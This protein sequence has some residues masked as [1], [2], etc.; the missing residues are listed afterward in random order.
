L[1]LLCVVVWSV[2]TNFVQVFQ[3]FISLNLN[4]FYNIISTLTLV[5]LHTGSIT[6]CFWM[7]EEAQPNASQQNTVSSVDASILFDEDRFLHLK[8]LRADECY[9]PLLLGERYF[10]PSDTDRQQR[11][12]EDGDGIP[13]RTP[14]PRE[15][16]APRD[17]EPGGRPSLDSKSGFALDPVEFDL[18]LQTFLRGQGVSS[19]ISSRTKGDMAFW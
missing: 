7:E 15:G 1:F 18:V 19:W 3:W 16:A 8:T 9:L 2:S 13:L 11:T 5:S 6:C 12:L 10:A 17:A 4:N 14:P